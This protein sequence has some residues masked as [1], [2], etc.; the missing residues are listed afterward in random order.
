MLNQICKKCICGLIIIAFISAFTA[1]T[2]NKKITPVDKNIA[3]NSE[4]SSNELLESSQDTSKNN[5]LRLDSWVG[6]YI[7]TE[8]INSKD[9][10]KF[11]EVFISKE[12]NDY[13][14][15]IKIH[16]EGAG[17]YSYIQAKINEDKNCIDFIFL[18]YLPGEDNTNKPYSLGDNLLSFTKT[19]TGISTHWGKIVPS[20]ENNKADGTYFK[21]Q[22]RSGGY[23]GHWYT[24][25]PDTGGN[26]TTIEIKDMSNMS[27]SFHLYFCRTYYYDGTNIKLENNI[28]K[29]VDNGD[30]KTSGTIEFVNNSIIVTIEKTD[31]PILKPGKTVFNYKVSEFKAVHITPNYG[32]TEVDLG[33]GIEIDFGRRI[34]STTYA[35]ATIRKANVENGSDNGH[36]EM[37]VKIKGNKLIF[38]PDYDKMKSFNEVIEAGQ[39]YELTIGEGQY[40]D[41]VGNINNELVLEFTTKK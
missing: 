1:C 15:K 21:I 37:K 23:I 9:Y 18:S 30:Y 36:V 20:N 16:D 26:S 29:F 11:Y 17:V 32:A 22:E 4:K 41:D 27:V 19:D 35:T 6:D 25:L 5:N 24:S 13:N 7:F 12:N 3:V 39:R 28:A 2:N 14:A 34:Y 40:S 8:Y 10:T 38:L 31:L 33:Q